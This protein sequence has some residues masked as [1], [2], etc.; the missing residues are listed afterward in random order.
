[1]VTLDP[2]EPWLDWLEPLSWL[3]CWPEEES[4]D[5]EPLDEDE[6]SSGVDPLCAVDESSDDEP[7]ELVPESLELV[8]CDALLAEVLPR[9]PVA[10]M[11]PKAIAKVASAAAATRRRIWRA[12]SARSRSR[13]RT[14]SEFWF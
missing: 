4:S 2:L 5:D 12:L 6:P 3:D 13:S 1:V 11:I 10:E 7:A 14:R 9:Y 8:P